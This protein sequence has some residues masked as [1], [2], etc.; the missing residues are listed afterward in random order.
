MQIP[1]AIVGQ[2]MGNVRKTKATCMLIVKQV[3]GFAEV[4]I[5][6]HNLFK[7]ESHALR[8]RFDLGLSFS[9]ILCLYI[10]VHDCSYQF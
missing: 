1:V 4:S 10:V 2:S 7:I 9:I 3:V 6:L 5:R 8:P